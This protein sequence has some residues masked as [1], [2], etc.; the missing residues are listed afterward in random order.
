[1]LYTDVSPELD[2]MSID[3]LNALQLR[4][5]QVASTGRVGSGVTMF[6]VETSTDMELNE[7]DESDAMSSETDM[8]TMSSDTTESDTGVSVEADTEMNAQ[9]D[10]SDD[11]IMIAP[12]MQDMTAEQDDP[13]MQQE[14]D[15]EAHSPEQ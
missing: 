3:E 12:D 1:M 11:E 7:T 8:E 13:V 10:M 2:E 14:M 6:Q 5:L 4:R 15:P 9:D